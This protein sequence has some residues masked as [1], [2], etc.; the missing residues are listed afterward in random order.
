MSKYH[1]NENGE[2]G[3]CRAQSGNCPFGGASEHFDTVQD[4]QA[5]AEKKLEKEFGATSVITAPVPERNRVSERAHFSDERNDQIDGL[6]ESIRDNMAGRGALAGTIYTPRIY[7]AELLQSR[8]K[9]FFKKFY[10]FEGHHVNHVR[11]VDFDDGSLTAGYYTLEG[12]DTP[13]RFD[14]SG[15]PEEPTDYF[16]EAGMLHAYH[17]LLWDESPENN[18]YASVEEGVITHER[19]NSVAQAYISDDDDDHLFAHAYLQSD[20]PDDTCTPYDPNASEEHQLEQAA[21]EISA[22]RQ[23]GVPRNITRVEVESHWLQFR[24][25][26]GEEFRVDIKQ[27]PH[28]TRYYLTHGE[29]REEVV[30]HFNQE[31]EGYAEGDTSSPFGDLK[32]IPYEWRTFY[33]QP[34]KSFK[35]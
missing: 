33:T 6:R 31:G 34:L 21:N 23:N 2:A 29:A 9:K 24:T 4:A 3:K 26:D 27:Y 35:E 13:L 1:V 12:D 11:S 30:R 25:G 7:A 19:W 18:F 17:T 16:M 20:T 22:L 28:L 32:E 8:V 15:M 10:V 14:C 5:A